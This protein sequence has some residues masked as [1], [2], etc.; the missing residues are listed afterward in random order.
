MSDT[1][2]NRQPKGTSVG[3]QF[4]PTKNPEP[5]LDLAPAGSAES[6]VAALEAQGYRRV[7]RAPL[8]R[9]PQWWRFMRHRAQER[10][11]RDVPVMDE[12]TVPGRS[13]YRM[14][15]TNS[16]VAL[17]SPSVASIKRFRTTVPDNTGFDVP[18]SSVFK[19]GQVDGFVRVV[20][21]GE[22]RWSTMPIGFPPEQ[23]GLVAESMQC[24]LE[25]RRPSRALDEVGDLLE[26]RRRRRAE[27]GVHLEPVRSSWIKGMGYEPSSGVLVMS[28]ESRGG[29]RHYGYKVPL[30]E[31]ARMA[32]DTTPG[33]YFNLRLRKSARRV[34][35][36]ACPSCGNVYVTQK[37]T[38]PVRA[39]ARGRHLLSVAA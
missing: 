11:D 12:R 21:D 10:D 6:A 28:A 33:R 2:R 18:V 37:H 32:S 5:H 17:R 7:E 35:V 31:F 27:A 29:T 39:N 16:Q 20:T 8:R 38:C 36:H 24:L 30:D 4:S 26:R 15:Y 3:G 34:E 23:A 19:S 1:S 9:A 14:W 22:G 25:S 13:S